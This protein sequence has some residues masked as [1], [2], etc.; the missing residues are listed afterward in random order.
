MCCAF[1]YHLS[2]YYYER[3]FHHCGSMQLKDEFS[4]HDREPSLMPHMA[5]TVEPKDIVSRARGELLPI[6]FN[7]LNP[8]NVFLRK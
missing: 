5:R 3:G 8:I 1:L 6:A 7:P 4:F 2:S